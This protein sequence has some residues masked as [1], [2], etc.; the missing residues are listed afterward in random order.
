METH[1]NAIGPYKSASI[2]SSAATFRFTIFASGWDAK[3][4]VSGVWN[5]GF[6]FGGI[7]KL[8][9]K[10]W[11]SQVDKIRISLVARRQV[12]GGAGA[13]VQVLF[14]SCTLPILNPTAIAD[15]V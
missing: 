2:F 11:L 4:A 5:L 12:Y 3:G 14:S 8:S 1:I 7:E 9:K 6:A 13:S 15:W 10:F